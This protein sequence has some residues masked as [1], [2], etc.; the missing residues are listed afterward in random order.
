MPIAQ[1]PFE[2]SRSY[3]FVE[4]RSTRDA[5]DA[6]HDMYAS[7]AFHVCL[8]FTRDD[9]NRHGRN[10]DGARIS[11]QV[12]PFVWLQAACADIF[13]GYSGR[14]TLPPLC[15][16]MT[17]ALLPAVATGNVRAAPIGVA[18]TDPATVTATAIV[19][20]PGIVNVTGTNATRTRT[21]KSS[22][23]E[24]RRGVGAPPLTGAGRT[25]HVPRLLSMTQKRTIEP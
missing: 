12:S 14:R 2:S 19:T 5:E 4:F 13:H 15:G 11:I 1:R 23:V 25:V 9:S 7:H 3:A 20:V 10:F 16:V 17:G 24:A 22:A 6:Y 18:A 8:H 21:T